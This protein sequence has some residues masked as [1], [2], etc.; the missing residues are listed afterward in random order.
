MQH[1]CPSPCPEASPANTNLEGSALKKL[2]KRKCLTCFQHL[3]S[4]TGCFVTSA[5]QKTHLTHRTG[6]RYAVECR[7][8]AATWQRGPISCAPR[9]ILVEFSILPADGRCCL[10]SS[11]TPV[12]TVA[13]RALSSWE[14]DGQNGPALR[15]GLRGLQVHH[16]EGFQVSLEDEYKHNHTRST[17]TS[18]HVGIKGSY[19]YLPIMKTLISVSKS[20]AERFCSKRHA[21]SV[22]ESSF[23]FLPE[24]HIFHPDVFSIQKC[25][26]ERSWRRSKIP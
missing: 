6:S 15:S 4:L 17:F 8:S 13:T 12:S 26:I 9:G 21:M 24:E 7:D 25:A 19:F 11:C 23:F 22:P 3:T 2:C 5:G 16:W 20:R 14:L 1:A 18:K 10:P